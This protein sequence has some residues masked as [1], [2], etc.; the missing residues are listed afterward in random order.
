MKTDASPTTATTAE[1]LAEWK[2]HWP[3]V[4]AASAGFSFYSVATYSTGLF[5]EPLQQAFGWNRSTV[6]SGLSIAALAALP[7]SPFVGVLIDKWGSRRLAIPSLILTALVMASFGLVNGTLP[8]WYALWSAYAIIALGIKATVWTAAISSVFTASRGL[9][10]GIVMSGTAV[11]QILAPPIVRWLIDTWGWRQGY[12]WISLGWAA[13]ALI[14]VVLFLFD[15]H[16]INKRT[17]RATGKPTAALALLPGLTIQEALRSPALW[18]IGAASFLTMFF[19]VAVLIHQ[20]PIMTE[21]GLTRTRAAELA[22]L[23]GFAGI[24]GK[25]ITGWLMDRM[26]AARISGITLGLAAIA[27]GMLLEPVRSPVTIVIAMM[28]IGY[29]G[30]AKLQIGA[31][32]TSRYG[33][34]RNFGKIYGVITSLVGLSVAMGPL[35][36]SRAFDI[37]GDYSPFLIAAIPGSLI[38]GLLIFSLG[39]YPTRDVVQ[40]A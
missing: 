28:I 25:L 19:G 2:A 27:F 31:Y 6:T 10:L 40:K 13:P 11:A 15:A 34:L 37:A 3:L 29:S 24:A 21:A 36:A 14:L 35:L 30:G 38:S 18:K 20:V 16:D 33:G 26:H 22:S 17:A 23:A 39:P 1:K 9:A 4:L 5:M 12:I 32:L 7:L 8:M